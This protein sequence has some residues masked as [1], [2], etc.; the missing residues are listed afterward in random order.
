MTTTIKQLRK[1]KYEFTVP[2][3]LDEL[4][5]LFHIGQVDYCAS[6]FPLKVGEKF[7]LG[8]FE[9][10]LHPDVKSGK[11][12]LPCFTHVNHPGK[13]F[14]VTKEMF[15]LSTENQL[16]FWKYTIISF[17]DLVRKHKDVYDSVIMCEGGTRKNVH[18][19]FQATGQ[20]L[21]YFKSNSCI[22]T[23]LYYNKDT[24]DVYIEFDKLADKVR[25]IW[26]KQEKLLQDKAL[27]EKAASKGFTVA[28]YF[29]GGHDDAAI[30]KSVERTKWII[31]NTLLVTEAKAAMDDLIEKMLTGQL[32]SHTEVTN[33]RQRM[34]KLSKA[35]WKAQ[36]LGKIR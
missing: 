3:T 15:I 20:N 2:E 28:E 21:N 36:G 24:Y 1:P 31:N 16:R 19:D 23:G 30:K 33:V 25:K 13:V 18:R 8:P 5:T 26:L 7:K 34:G 27:E 4:K 29:E 11:E 17:V 22:I 14:S 12:R 35:L 32:Y 10:F 9:T 6:L